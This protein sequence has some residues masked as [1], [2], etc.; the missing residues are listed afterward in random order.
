MTDSQLQLDIYDFIEHRTENLFVVARAGSGKTTTIVRALS[1]LPA[2]APGDV[3]QRSTRFLAF[4]KSIADELQRRVPPHVACS[5]FHSLGFS[6]LKQVLGW[7]VKVDAA[8]VKRLVWANMRKDDPDTQQVIRLVGLAKNLGVGVLVEDED[9]VWASIINQ[10]DMPIEESKKAIATARNV[11]RLSNFDRNVIDFDD[12]LYLAL[13]LNAPFDKLDYIFVDEAQDMNPVR[14]EVIR[15]SMHPQTRVF[16]VGDPQQAIY[17]FT[18]AGRD[19]I[20]GMIRDFNCVTLPL[21]V[22]YRCGK[23]IIREAQKYVPQIQWWDESPEGIVKSL[24]NYGT[25][26]FTPGSSILCRNVAPLVSFAYGLLR[27][28]VPCVIVGR[29]VGAKLI[30][31]VRKLRAEDLEQLRERLGEWRNKEVA[32]AE[33]EHLDPSHIDDQ[34]DC[35]MAFVQNADYGATPEDIIARIELM[36]TEQNDSTRVSL[37]SMHKS[38]GM[39][40][41]RVLILDRGLCP[42]KWARQEWQQEQE[43]NLIYVATTRAKKELYYIASACWKDEKKVD[44]TPKATGFIVD[45]AGVEAEKPPLQLTGP[46]WEHPV[47]DEGEDI[48]PF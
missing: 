31:V 25:E 36:F 23:S 32:A 18:G 16:F 1:R 24:P 28:D 13:A 35:I 4:N 17:G 5:T 30:S 29:D 6:A 22:S 47:Q 2:R 10:F 3:M 9:R 45:T 40:W 15:R 26:M 39:E 37:S 20:E 8:K 48:P 33:R 41:D 14:I 44:E 27:R 11:L 46:N 21:S 7:K 34:Y 19:S 38:K 42:S 43:K 12:M